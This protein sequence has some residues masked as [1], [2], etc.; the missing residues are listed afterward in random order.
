MLVE[1]RNLRVQFPSPR[2]ESEAVRNVSLHAW[3][4]EA[5]HRRR[6]R[7]GQVVTARSLLRLVPAN[8]R[9]RADG[10][11][12]DGIDMLAPMSGAAAHPR[13]SAQG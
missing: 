12:F 1:I 3:A 4:G 11:E 9:T 2:G 13:Q 7:V 8:A 10:L 6:E 5:R